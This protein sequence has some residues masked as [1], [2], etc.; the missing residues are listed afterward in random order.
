M[1]GTGR[2]ATVFGGTGFL[3]HAVVQ[4]LA[5]RG[6]S[7]RVPTRDTEKAK[8]LKLMGATG[9]VVP[10]AASIRSDAA[11]TTAIAGA[12][13]VINLIGV[14]HE[15]SGLTFQTAHVET[16]ARIARIARSEGV[17]QFVHVSAL[18]AST[19]AKAR[20]AR[21]KAV[22][23][24]AVRA[25]FPTAII[26]RPSIMF[27]PRDDFFNRFARMARFSPFIPLIGGGFTRFQPVY[28]GDVAEAIM[29][30]LDKK[31]AQGH[32]FALGGQKRYFFEELMEL[33]TR[34]MGI[35]RRHLPLPWFA[36]SLLASLAEFMP[37]P[38]LTRDQVELLKT[39]NLV[40]VRPTG[41]L[42]QLRG[43]GTLDLLGIK[44]T[45]L[46]DILPTYIQ[47]FAASRN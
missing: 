9:Q 28:V 14:L 21:T 40:T 36:A 17:R 29:A 43:V 41:P 4:A 6:Y 26:F 30:G 3:G 16:A 20:Y 5:K 15:K 7:V 12:D 23:E 1:N 38:P 35:R 11:V 19:E 37:N 2:I 47:D 39:D 24:E 45:P 18:G 34:T 25:F 33:L 8:D 44:P 13:V 31:E 10:L 32:I 46:E 27:G 22:G 42:A